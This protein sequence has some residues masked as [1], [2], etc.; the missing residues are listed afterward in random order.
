MRILYLMGQGE[1]GLP[2]YT[3]ELANAV[4]RAHDV[5]VMKPDRSTAD[6]LFDAAVDVREP[7]RSID[8]SMSKLYNRDLSPAAALR[9]MASYREMRRIADLDVDIVHETT[10]LF[11]HV[12]LFARATGVDRSQ[13]FVVTRHEVT[14]NRFSLSRPPVLA[15]E[16]LMALLPAVD[17]DQTVVHTRR[18]KAALGNR[19]ADWGRIDVIPHGAYSVFGDGGSGAAPEPDTILFFGNLVPPKGVDTL[20]RAVPHVTERIPDLTV[21]VAGDGQIPGA[22]DPVIEAHREHF[23]IHNRFIPN[24]EVAD[25]FERAECV[26]LPYREQNGTKGHSGVLSTA[27]TFGKPVV[28]STAGVF[29]EYVGER[30]CGPVVPPED[31]ER[32]ADAI[33][34]VLRNPAERERMAD[35]SRAMASALSWD[36]IAEKHVEL[37]RRLL[38]D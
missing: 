15:E 37:Y 35:A 34:S 33:V 26:V 14:M 23:E 10:D 30:G 6:E 8:L 16:L 7:F 18:Q 11:P 1:G 13:P 12:K 36:T 21:V 3:A 24:D 17:I 28:A 38:P 4:A 32:L 25:F 20:I 22:V 29:P 19:R 2:H 9:G 31:P 27:F 5:I